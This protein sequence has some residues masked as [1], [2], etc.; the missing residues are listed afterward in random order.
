M[1]QAKSTTE[2][3]TT[4]TTSSPTGVEMVMEFP[5][6]LSEFQVDAINAIHRDENVLVTAKTGSGKTLI[7]IYQIAYALK[8]GMRVFYTTPIKALSNDK[9]REIK[10][11]FPEASV[12]IMTGDKKDNP[13]AD[14]VIMTAE[15]LRNLLYKKGTSTECHGLT[16]GLTL[17]RVDAVVVDEA[18]YINDKGRGHVWEET[19]SLLPKEIKVIL[20]SA[21]LNKPAE[22]AQWLTDKRE[23]TTN[24]IETAYRV[25]PLTHYAAK[26]DVTSGELQ[27]TE[28]CATNSTGSEVYDPAAYKKWSQ[29]KY[30]DYKKE[31]EFSEQTKARKADVLAV[32]AAA[33]AAGEAIPHGLPAAEGKVHQTSY[34]HQLNTTI[35]SLEARDMLPA[36]FFVFNRKQCEQYAAAVETSLLEP[37]QAAAVRH[38]IDFHLQPY[39]ETLSTVTQYHN[40]IDLLQKGVAYHHSGLLPL[41]K[42]MVEI[43]FS[44]GL[45]KVLFCTETFAVGINMPTRTVVFTELRKHDNGGLRTL[46][47][48]EYIQMAGRA[49]RRGKDVRGNVVYLPSHAPI[50]PEEMQTIMKGNLPSL[51][52]RITF[53]Y[54]FVLKTIH[55]GEDTWKRVITQ[56][57]WYRQQRQELIT[58]GKELNKTISD[59][60]SFAAANH[61]GEQA[62]VDTLTELER[63]RAEFKSAVN[64]D[65][66]KAQA[67]LNRFESRLV[68]AKWAT[69]MEA[70]TAFKKMRNHAAQLNTQYL[71]AKERL[72]DLQS[73]IQPSVTFLQEHGYLEPDGLKLT[74]KGV[75]ATEV[76]EGHP[77]LMTELYMSGALDALNPTQIMGVLATFITERSSQDDQLNSVRDDIQPIINQLVH[78]R[79]SLGSGEE[80]RLSTEYVE[81]AMDWMAGEPASEICS[82]Y[83]IYEG[84]LTRI[85]M[86]LNNLLEELRV[87]AT[88][89]NNV[90]LLNTIKDLIIVHGI[91]VPDSLYTRM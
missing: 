47:K 74:P 37:S 6:P 76:N 39:K 10:N 4:S 18:H 15:I 70:W 50:Y 23:R 34:I 20:L 36:I 63:L 85:V 83:N 53:S 28:I 41:L 11:A 9:I 59:C 56:S 32:K 25:V 1:L 64:A 54:E 77:I 82:K 13:S 2:P 78:I 72:G 88:I 35:K 31:R 62:T 46:R 33:K 45:I 3:V 60:E 49:G 22:F 38:T 68:G 51:E 14:I 81:T 8:K 67:T 84:N 29:S 80:W 48:D 57:Y 44:R 24:L 16:A 79:D 65:K 42:E 40:L 73:L 12:G 43:L 71:A 19:L 30:L 55:A 58:M 69:A 90:T 61:L 5:F 52:S 7:G 75:I 91:A 86:K 89:T 87:L 66:K 27:L 17:D 26:I 21:T